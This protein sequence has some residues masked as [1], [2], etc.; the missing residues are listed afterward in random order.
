[1]SNSS[2]GSGRAELFRRLV[3]LGGLLPPADDVTTGAFAQV[4]TDLTPTTDDPVGVR[5]QVRAAFAVLSNTLADAV[6]P[7][8][9]HPMAI[10]SPKEALAEALNVIPQ[11][12]NLSNTANP[13][14]G[15]LV[16][17]ARAKPVD[18]DLRKGPTG[19]S[20]SLPA[21]LAKIKEAAFRIARVRGDDD[22]D[23]APRS[24]P[25]PPK[26]KVTTKPAVTS[27][28][29]I[30]PGTQ[31]YGGRVTVTGGVLPYIPLLR[32]PPSAAVNLLPTND[33]HVFTLSAI[34]PDPASG[35]TSVPFEI[36]WQDAHGKPL[37]RDIVVLDWSHYLAT[38]VHK[39][40]MTPV[41]P[42]PVVQEA[43]T[44]QVY[45]VV[46]EVKNLPSPFTVDA[47]GQSAAPV[48]RVDGED[49][50]V[51]F[52]LSFLVPADP[53]TQGPPTSFVAEVKDK[54]GNVA[55][56]CSVPVTFTV[57]DLTLE[58][59][60]ADVLTVPENSTITLHGSGIGQ[61]P[62]VVFITK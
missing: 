55:C 1:M 49:L 5:K 52:D 3:T 39:A 33:P 2:S 15:Q 20:T 10:G 29:V 47:V 32:T 44:V 16:A 36:V 11:I 40:Q 28:K 45:E 13:V 38:S 43:A 27:S 37:S 4:R 48:W 54:H 9:A 7:M 58:D 42:G 8:E 21:D 60:L 35:I 31:L 14:V 30:Q 41:G 57:A 17:A 24:K 23:D 51:W 12:L 22:D 19:L 56:Q 18:V 50:K 6:P 26:P 34:A 25:V 59:A 46:F 53:T 62:T 61:K